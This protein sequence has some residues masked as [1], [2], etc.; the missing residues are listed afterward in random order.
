[1]DLGRCHRLADPGHHAQRIAAPLAPPPFEML[2]RQIGGG[3]S[4]KGRVARAHALPGRAVALGAGGDAARR[5]AV[6]IEGVAPRLGRA[7]GHGHRV[8][9]SGDSLAVIPAQP[10]RNRVHLRVVA[11]PFRIIF[12]L[13][14]KIAGPQPRQPRRPRAIALALQAMTA[15]TGVLGARVAAAERNHFA[16]RCEAVRRT[17]VGPAA[18]AGREQDEDTGSSDGHSLGTTCLRRWFR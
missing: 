12:K 9:I 14:G 1:M 7:G 8:I 16:S 6:L 4:G 11:E 2:L 18:G 5:I 13:A 17:L 10:L 15:E 3:L